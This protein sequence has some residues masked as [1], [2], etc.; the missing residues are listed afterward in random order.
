MEKSNNEHIVYLLAGGNVNNSAHK[1]KKMLQLLSKNVG[2]IEK[3]SHF[4]RSPAWGYA[5]D[6]PFINMAICLTTALHYIDLL[7]VTQNIEKQLGRIHF[8]D[9]QYHDRTMDI[10]ILFYDNVIYRSPTLTIPH[11]LLQ[12]RNFVLTPLCEIAENLQHPVYQQTI[13]ELKAICTDKSKVEVF[14]W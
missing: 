5:S 4:Y 13:K 9:S 3:K 14:N 12:E 6:L 1:Y 7:N 10:D 8:P 2:K 11:P